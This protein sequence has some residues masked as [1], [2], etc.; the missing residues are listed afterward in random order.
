MSSPAVHSRWF[1]RPRARWA[2]I[3]GALAVIGLLLLIHHLNQPHTLPEKVAALF[4][5]ADPDANC[6]GGEPEQKR[7]SA[8]E[9][10]DL[11]PDLLAKAQSTTIVSCEFVG[12][13]TIVV[14]FHSRG[15][16][17]RAFAGS[18]SAGNRTWCITGAGA[19]D[20]VTVNHEGIA[21][22][23]QRLHGSIRLGNVQLGNFA[24]WTTRQRS[25]AESGGSRLRSDVGLTP[26]HH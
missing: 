4:D 1:E 15:D 11:Y 5:E 22:F 8:S 12:P 19:F 13:V 6:L 9:R 20:E 21:W 23:C 3:G 14:E 26:Y 24:D 16:L 18:R 7:I 25:P 10:P 2:V 17:E